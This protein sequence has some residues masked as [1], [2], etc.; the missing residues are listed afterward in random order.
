LVAEVQ[1]C[2]LL[3][4]LTWSLP[5][6]CLLFSH[7]IVA[8]IVEDII[9]FIVI[10]ISRLSVWMAW[11]HH[12][13]RPFSD[14]CASPSLYSASSP[15]LLTKYSILRNGIWSWFLGSIKMFTLSDEI[16]I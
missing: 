8:N 3:T 16:W 10:S 6:S 13:P 7:Y 2:S 1:R 4:L 15:I 12:A 5:S 14:L 9:C 11:V